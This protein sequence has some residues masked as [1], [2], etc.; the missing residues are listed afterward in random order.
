LTGGISEIAYGDGKYLVAKK[1]ADRNGVDLRAC[2]FY[3]DSMSDGWLL[4]KV[5]HPVVINPDPRLRKHAEAK[6]WEIRDWGK[7]AGIAPQQKKKGT[8]FL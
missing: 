7:S 6:G 3:S 1:W 4:E 2:Y 8:G 5:G